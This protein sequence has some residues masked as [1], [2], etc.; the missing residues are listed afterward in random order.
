MKAKRKK[1]APEPTRA[2]PARCRQWLQQ[3]AQQS[4]QAT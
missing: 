1:P 4:Q 2:E 3:M